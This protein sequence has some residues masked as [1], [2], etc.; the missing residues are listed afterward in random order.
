MSETKTIHPALRKTRTRSNEERQAVIAKI[1]AY[2][3]THP[4]AKKTDLS[5]FLMESEGVT[6]SVSYNMINWCRIADEKAE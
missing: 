3:D 1:R 2:L 5:K 6:K 4:K